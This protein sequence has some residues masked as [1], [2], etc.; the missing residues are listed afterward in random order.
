[1]DSVA[2]GKHIQVLGSESVFE[3]TQTEQSPPQM[4]TVEEENLTLIPQI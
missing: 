2:D 1:M 4:L 3:R